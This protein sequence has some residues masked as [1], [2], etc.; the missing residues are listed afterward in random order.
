MQGQVGLVRIDARAQRQSAVVVSCV[1]RVSALNKPRLGIRWAVAAFL[2]DDKDGQESA[3]DGRAEPFPV[4]E[5]SFG[6][7][8]VLLA[9]S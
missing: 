3:V 7:T 2:T 8:T 6:R 4:I 1:G 9:A 5:S